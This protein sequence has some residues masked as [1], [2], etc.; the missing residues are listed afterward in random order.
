[1]A[2]IYMP[3]TAVAKM[4]PASIAS[5]K[6]SVSS[7]AGT[8]G[9]VKSK[10]KDIWLD[11]ELNDGAEHDDIYDSRPQPEYE[12]IYKQSVNS[13]DI[14]LQMGN[15]TPSTAS[16]EDMVIKI[17]LPG[18]MAKEM[19]LDVKQKFLDLRTNKFKLGLHLPHSVDH[20]N[21]RAQWDADKQTLTVT[22][23]MNREYDFANF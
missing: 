15:K 7:T 21:G 11:E 1:M 16:C 22:L 2:H 8:T 3:Q 4:G 6:P 20:K 12:I 14:Y 5:V 18:T 9:D 17:K 13:E 19:D 23:R 10:S